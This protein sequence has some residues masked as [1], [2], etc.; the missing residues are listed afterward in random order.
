MFT[1][2][3][4]KLSAQNYQHNSATLQSIPE[5]YL[6]YACK[7]PWQSSQNIPEILLYYP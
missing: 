4:A 1:H 7:A 5:T 6:K 3:E 2:Y